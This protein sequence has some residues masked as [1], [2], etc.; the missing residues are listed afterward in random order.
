V[1]IRP[2]PWGGKMSP[3]R[4]YQRVYRYLGYCMYFFLF[5]R[6]RDSESAGQASS[7]FSFCAWRRLSMD[8]L[9]GL[10]GLVEVMVV[11]AASDT[12]ASL[13]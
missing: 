3:N 13:P 2:G 1:I 10:V 5:R 11:V 7:C 9:V 8:E 6:C 4:G 12:V